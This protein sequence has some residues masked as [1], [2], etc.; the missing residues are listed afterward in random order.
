M[1]YNT[2]MNKCAELIQRWG[3]E[4]ACRGPDEFS[5]VPRWFSKQRCFRSMGKEEEA[6]LTKIREYGSAAVN[7]FWQ[8]CGASDYEQMS[9]D[10]L[11]NA[12]LCLARASHGPKRRR[13]IGKALPWPEVPLLGRVG[14]PSMSP[15][16]ASELSR[17][18]RLGGSYGV[19]YRA[20]NVDTNDLVVVKVVVDKQGRCEGRELYFLKQVQGSEFIVKLH[21]GLSSP[22]W[23]A[24]VTERHH[25]SLRQYHKRIGVVPQHIANSIAS[26]LAQ[27]FLHIHLRHVLHRDV[28]AGNVL[29]RIDGEKVQAALCDFGL[30]SYVHG[31]GLEL[32]HRS[33][34]VTQSWSRAPEIF[35]AAGTD[36]DAKGNWIPATTAKYGAGVDVWGWGVVT[37]SMALS[38]PL[39]G[40]TP[41]T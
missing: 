6:I 24:I 33:G 37:M 29:L 30:S 10:S 4:E 32:K 7:V 9:A 16:L 13:V 39:Y 18:Y 5:P 23:S 2:A 14:F 3:L 40:G 17:K 34:N 26:Q 35:F 8:S 11:W 27:A 36:V 38:R 12:V 1:P 25:C 20:A 21:D 31:E 41:S 19:V 22:F 28:H 15:P